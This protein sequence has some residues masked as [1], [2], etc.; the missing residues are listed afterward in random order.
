MSFYKRL[1]YEEGEE[2]RGNG[3]SF[4]LT[5]WMPAGIVYEKQDTKSKH[6]LSDSS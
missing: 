1:E 5:Q 4:K 2:R 3:F 6:I